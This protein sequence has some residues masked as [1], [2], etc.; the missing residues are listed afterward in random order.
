MEK[1]RVTLT[2]IP[3]EDGS[4]KIIF[5]SNG[6]SLKPSG[7]SSFETMVDSNTTVL[8]G[9]VSKHKNTAADRYEE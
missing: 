7:N 2:L 4:Y 5:N 9:K 8:I 1:I 6:E 3:S